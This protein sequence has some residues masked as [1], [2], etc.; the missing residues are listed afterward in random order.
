MLLPQDLFLYCL[1]RFNINFLNKKN[2]FIVFFA[3]LFLVFIIGK[4]DNDF[5]FKGYYMS[6][7]GFTLMGLN[8]MTCLYFSLSSKNKMLND[9]LQNK[10]LIYIGKIS[11]SLY[12]FHWFILILFL[13]TFNSILKK[14]FNHNNNL[15]AITLCFISTFIISA[16][17][18]RFFEKPII[19]L[20]KKFV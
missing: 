17:S 13:P 8:F 15:I 12:I 7:F 19:R 10:I 1:L 16:L 6:S 20:K 18:Y 11:Y 9:I 2:S 14:I 3:T 4:I 5:S